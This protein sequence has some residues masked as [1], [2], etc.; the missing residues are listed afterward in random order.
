M[1]MT[2]RSPTAHSFLLDADENLSDL[3]SELSVDII[4]YSDVVA[5]NPS[6][7]L[8]AP[9]TAVSGLE[10]PT[11]PLAH[12]P[13]PSSTL[14][15]LTTPQT[16]NPM[17]FQKPP[18][19]PDPSPTQIQLPFS[20]MINHPTS[21]KEAQNSTQ[22]PAKVSA[23]SGHIPWI[24]AYDSELMAEQMTMVEKGALSEID[25]SDLVN[26]RWDNSPTTILNW[27]DFLA[28]GDHK[29]IDLVIT[30]FNI[31]VKWVLSE[32]VLTQNIHERA[33]TIMKYIHL[34]AH[35]RRL[36][37]YA[38]MLQITVALT[39]SDC[40]RLRRTWDLVH[41]PERSLLKNME[42]LTRPLRNFHD[43]RLEMET[44]DLTEGCIPFVGMLPKTHAGSHP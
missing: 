9:G 22:S 8:A 3:S 15:R 39:S 40:S 26:M 10:I 38:T 19:T 29:G 16:V 11:H 44:A 21:S 37:N 17:M 23:S 20:K 24:L 12:P 31:M 28:A 18:L 25:W 30:R 13:S 42:A 36:H 41:P 7:L 33:Q 34:A 32:V 4:N 35:A 14:H 1:P 5:R 2:D 43:L 6:P 27:V